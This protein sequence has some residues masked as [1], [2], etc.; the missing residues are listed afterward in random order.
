MARRVLVFL[1][2]YRRN[3]WLSV[4]ALTYLGRE[5]SP[6]GRTYGPVPQLALKQAHMFDP[7]EMTLSLN[8]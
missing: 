8:M 7:K 2:V 6:F 1:Q 3:P 5:S 4:D